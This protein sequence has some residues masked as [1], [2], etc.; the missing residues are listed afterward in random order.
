MMDMHTHTIAS[1][2]VHRPAEVV[3]MAKAAGLSG[4]VVT[5][6]DT[7]GGVEEA[8]L[9]GK[10]LGLIVVPGI[11][12]ST[13]GGERDI[14]ILGYGFQLDDPIFAQ[15]A[16]EQ[17]ELRKQRNIHIL[18][19]LQQA[20]NITVTLEEVQQIAGN[21]EQSSMGRPHI[22]QA[23]VHK[24][25]VKDVQEAFALYLGKGCPA[26][27]RPKR[28]AP[29]DAAQRI[30]DAG[31][32]AVIAHPGLYKDD[33]IVRRVIEKGIDGI[34]VYHADHLPSEEAKYA[35]WAEAYGLVATGGSDFHGAREGRLYHG[36]VGARRV[37]VSVLEQLGIL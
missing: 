17:R 11:E 22:A 9:E 26:Y 32:A 27:T 16:Y 33:E 29:W 28:I 6:H 7:I 2:G 37:P 12:I 18:E 35:K 21:C 25:I 8:M 10:K 23:L 20:A 19:K 24:G 13:D 15:F 1:D 3:Q 31:G 5:D 14:H 34:E 4:V 30:R 36:E